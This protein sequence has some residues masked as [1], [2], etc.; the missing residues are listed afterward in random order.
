MHD[1]LDLA[2]NVLTRHREQRLLRRAACFTGESRR[3]HVDDGHRE[4]TTAGDGS[5][6]RESKLGMRSAA[7]RDQ[8]AIDRLGP[9]KADHRHVAHA[10]VPA[11]THD[12][13]G[14]LARATADRAIVRPASEEE[15]RSELS[16]SRDDTL[17]DRA[18]DPHQRMH[19]VGQ[20]GRQL[21]ETGAGRT[22]GGRARAQLLVRRHL[23]DVHDRQ[24]RC[25]GSP[26]RGR[27]VR[28]PDEIGVVN[29][30]DEDPRRLSEEWHWTGPP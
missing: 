5:R 23:D 29:D 18:V 30:R 21:V 27:H 2:T 20:R 28:E 1:P 11:G 7:D 19:G 26:P 14:H 13:L 16:R 8:H 22:R 25:A 3:H 4:P 9:A 24:F 6:H 15:I 17:R 10:R 12:R